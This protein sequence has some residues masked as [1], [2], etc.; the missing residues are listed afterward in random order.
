M[1]VSRP[2]ADIAFIV[3]Y[4]LTGAFGRLDNLQFGTPE[5]STVT[6]ANGAY[7]FTG[8]APGEYIVREIVPED[9]R[10]MSPLGGPP[11]RVGGGG[12]GSGLYRRAVRRAWADG[13]GGAVPLHL[14]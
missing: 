6:D 10:Q 5:A 4:T 14:A 3:A 2:T 1:T 11:G 7:A 12:A 8:L 13:R 9:F